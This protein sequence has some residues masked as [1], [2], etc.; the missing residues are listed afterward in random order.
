MNE[1]DDATQGSS[2][3]LDTATILES[4]VVIDPAPDAYEIDEIPGELIDEA[5]RLTTTV[6][7]AEDEGR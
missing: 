7:V 6:D 4:T 2:D 5:S 1:L 3:G